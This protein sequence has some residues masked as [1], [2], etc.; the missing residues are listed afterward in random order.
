M[1]SKRGSALGDAFC[2]YGI[3]MDLDTLLFLSILWGAFSHS[4]LDLV[5]ASRRDSRDLLLYASLERPK[6]PKAI[7]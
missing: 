7:P 6:R 4:H 2:M 3:E 5:I 1:S